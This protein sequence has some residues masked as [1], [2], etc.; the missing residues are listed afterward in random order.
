MPTV[1]ASRDSAWDLTWPVQSWGDAVARVSAT[2][3]NGV[4]LR[5]PIRSRA[6]LLPPPRRRL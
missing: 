6:A 5:A 3:A 4:W 2:G 1:S